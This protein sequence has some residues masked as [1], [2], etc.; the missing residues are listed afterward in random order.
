MLSQEI[1]KAGIAELM[2]AFNMELTPDQIKLWY[3]YCKKLT[4]AEFK[5]K[6]TGC[7]ET[8]KKRPCIA[9]LLDTDIEVKPVIK[10]V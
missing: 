9:D 4:D 6:V 2:L 7:I 5:K 1:F 3:K 8:C 10:Y